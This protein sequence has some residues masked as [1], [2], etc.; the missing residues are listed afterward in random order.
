[1]INKQDTPAT[2]ASG[3]GTHQACCPCPNDHNINIGCRHHFA[4]TIL[5]P[6]IPKT[7]FGASTVPLI[8]P[9]TLA[10]W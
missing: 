3:A 8:A 5:K 6:K 1:M 9:A 7:L 2:L 10:C 4:R